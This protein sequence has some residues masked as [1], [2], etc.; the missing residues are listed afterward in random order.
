[1][2][3]KPLSRRVETLPRS[4]IREMMALAD[5]TPGAIRLEAGEPSFSTP[6][7]II[8]AAFQD[9]R[10]GYTKY[11]PNAGIASLRDAI[12]DRHTKRLRRSVARDEVFVATGA[13]GALA[14]A[15]LTIVEE[16]DEVLV[17]DPGWPNYRS[18]VQ[19]AGGTPLPYVLHSERDFQ[20]DLAELTDCFSARTK[21]IILNSPANPTGSMLS[22]RTLESIVAL[23]TRFDSYVVSD[24][25]YEELVFD[26]YN[27]VSAGL[28][29]REGRVVVVSG[30]SKTYAMTGWRI[31]WAVADR[32][33]VSLMGTLQEPL[34]ACASSVS[35]RAA[36]AAL[37]GPQSVVSE[38]RDAYQRRRDLVCDLLR[39]AG[40]LAANPHGA[41]Y[42]MVD[43]S[44]LGIPSRELARA[45]LL[46]ELVATAPGS[47]FGRAGEGMLRI[48][49]A[50]SE[51]LLLEG[52]RRIV[53]F[54]ERH[55]AGDAATLAM[56][57][58]STLPLP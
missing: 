37:R 18:I 50:T 56:G 25:V 35:Q 11:T 23:A 17:P 19:L 3:V 53:R 39:P 24:E 36:E 2:R 45:L 6:E 30:C 51:D 15:I 34:T 22:H 38:M 55:K 16:G 40:Y 57:S 33:L 43:L 10:D 21:A 26:G 1:M 41:F 13:T 12:A 46:E 20:P 52:C 42:A 54:A 14:A 48:S 9:A 8:A 29:D 32:R 5:A 4:G 7:H 47:T 28:F 27:H 49:L 58:R 44:S 31:G